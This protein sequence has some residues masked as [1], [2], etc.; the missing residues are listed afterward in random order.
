MW[1]DPLKLNLTPRNIEVKVFLS[2]D[3]RIYGER[4]CSTICYGLI[5]NLAF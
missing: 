1:N 5:D 2:K 4:I 3:Y